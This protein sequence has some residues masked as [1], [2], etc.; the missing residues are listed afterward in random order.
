M[1]VAVRVDCVALGDE[2]AYMVD[3]RRW[4]SLIVVPDL[5][6]G[7]WVG[8]LGEWMGWLTVVVVLSDE[9]DWRWGVAG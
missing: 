9:I 4:C 7:A 2:R 3:G 8:V 6:V 1:V 5:C